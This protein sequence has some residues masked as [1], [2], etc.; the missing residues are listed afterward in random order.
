[1]CLTVSLSACVRAHEGRQEEEGRFVFSGFRTFLFFFVI[2]TASPL[3]TTNK[4]ELFHYIA[5]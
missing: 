5:L 1:M 3:Q 4:R 2:N